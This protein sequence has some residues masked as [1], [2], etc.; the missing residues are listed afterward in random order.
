MLAQNLQNLPSHS[1]HGV[2]PKQ[3]ARRGKETKEVL[4]EV[5]GPLALQIKLPVVLPAKISLFRKS[6]ELQPGISNPWQNHRQ[7]HQTK[8]RLF[9]RGKGALLETES[10]LE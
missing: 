7:V 8:R 3:I 5:S 1:F 6:R 4:G 10:P 2:P 9:Y